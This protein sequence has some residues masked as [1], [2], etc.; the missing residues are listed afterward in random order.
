MLEVLSYICIFIGLFMIVTAV[1]GCHKL[2]D[3]FSKMHAA[4]VGDAVGCPLVLLGISLQSS[5]LIVAIK[6]IIL[7]FILL[8]INPTAGYILNYIALKNDLSPGVR[9]D[10]DNA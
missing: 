7:A 4:S 3:Y 5:S 10:D 6:I 8:I 1:I 2:P 9:K